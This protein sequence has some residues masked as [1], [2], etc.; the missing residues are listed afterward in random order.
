MSKSISTALPFGLGGKHDEK[1]ERDILMR[2]VLKAVKIPDFLSYQADMSPIRNQGQRGA[3]V[4]FGTCAVKEYQER[5]Q[6]GIKGFLDFSEEWV[7]DQ[8]K[9]P[10][11]GAEVRDG[12]KVLFNSGV[13]K[14]QYMPYQDVPDESDNIAFK[15]T[16]TAKASA[17]NYKAGSYARI[18]S[19]EGITQSL[20]INGPCM[21]GIP[22]YYDWFWPKVEADNWATIVKPSGAEAGGHDVCI[23]GYDIKSKMFIVRNSWDTDWGT[24]K[25]KK[26][27]QPE[28]EKRGW[29][30]KTKPVLPAKVLRVF[31]FEEVGQVFKQIRRQEKGF[32]C[33]EAGQ[34][35]DVHAGKITRLEDDALSMRLGELL[36][37]AEAYGVSVGLVVASDQNDIVRLLDSQK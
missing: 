17:R 11:G 33:A 37:L 25:M 30:R 2:Q 23:V 9:Q 3:C 24:M 21:I 26:E 20:A 1:D 14:E 29:T 28:G 36:R 18:E 13:C 22:W 10:G 8:I 12:F 31:N 7:Y 16:S 27:D 34:L 19:V 32:S 4:A 5:K 35:A 6:R 15:P